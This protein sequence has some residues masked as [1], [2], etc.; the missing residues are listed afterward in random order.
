MQTNKQ[1]KR[2]ELFNVKN[3]L[4]AINKDFKEVQEKFL[5]SLNSCALSEALDEDKKTQREKLID[6]KFALNQYFIVYRKRFL[7]LTH[8]EELKKWDAKEP[9]DYESKFVEQA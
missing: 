4:I 3:Q 6:F 2:K 9:L 1:I 8:L 5:Q 7:L